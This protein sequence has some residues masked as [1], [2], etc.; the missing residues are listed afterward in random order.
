M[1]FH[2]AKRQPRNITA[3]HRRAVNQTTVC[4]AASIILRPKKIPSAVP[5]DYARRSTPGCAFLST[6]GMA[7]AARMATGSVPF[8]RK[9]HSW[10][11]ALFARRVCC[12]TARRVLKM[13][14]LWANPLSKR[15]S[16]RSPSTGVQDVQFSASYETRCLLPVQRSW[17][18]FI[19]VQEKEQKKKSK[20]IS[21]LYSASVF[22][23][24]LMLWIIYHLLSFNK[25]YPNQL[26]FKWK[27]I[28]LC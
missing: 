12:V 23:Q 26:G 19:V 25:N 6:E 13:K 3:I 22:S 5:I 27:V 17:L 15:A 2:S 24:N 16:G 7:F 8:A 11:D 28:K 10:I 14:S 20:S 18:D 9:R 21:S 4:S 1:A